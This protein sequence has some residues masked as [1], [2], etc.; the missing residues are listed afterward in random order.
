VSDA[1]LV[2]R[3]LDEYHE[4]WIAPSAIRVLAGSEHQARVTYRVALPDGSTQIIRAFRADQPAPAHGR[5]VAGENV[6]AWLVGR[7]RTLAMLAEAAYSAP[8]PVRT[9]TGEL[10]GVAGPWLTWAT[11][12]TDGPLVEPSLRQLQLTGAALGHLHSVAALPG[13]D[14]IGDG[15]AGLAPRHPAVAVPASLARLEAVQSRLP[16][17]WRPMHRVFRDV[18]ARI[19]AA[20]SL[21]ETVVHGDVWARNVVQAAASR[22]MFIDW[23]T[24]GR[25]LA[26]LDLGSAL[27]ECHLD[28]ALRDDQPDRW[29]IRPSA[30]RIAAIAA[31]YAGVRPLPAAEIDVLPA[32]VTFSAAVAGSV[33]FEQALLTGVSG[34]AMDARLARLANRLDVAAEVA[35]LARTYL[36]G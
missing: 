28:A 10:I 5:D 14:R 24:G 16:A 23:E 31:G 30:D 3:L 15:P 19:G 32:A 27:L 4:R 6:A 21:P 12:F 29:L 11:T 20:S 34:A 33:H 7:A 2:G 36:T 22:V 13:G 18:L 25:G 9:R 8:R 35:A 17:A 26:V 1:A